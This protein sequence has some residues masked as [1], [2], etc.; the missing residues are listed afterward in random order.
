MINNVTIVT[1]TFGNPKWIELVDQRSRL[2]ANLQALQAPYIHV[3]TENS[4][5]D[6]RNEGAKRAETDFLCFLDADDFLDQDFILE[7]NKCISNTENREL[8]LFQ[9]ATKT[10]MSDE[11][12]FIIPRKKLLNSNFLII[13]TVV[14]RKVFLDIGGFDRD[15]QALEDWDLWIRCAIYGCGYTEVPS[16]IYEVANEPNSRNK[17]SNKVYSKIK[18]RYINCKGELL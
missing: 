1:G 4:L 15:L 11:Q 18:S 16:A 14:S 2:S 7:M 10:F 3:H 17:D 6:A 5:A 8:T 9:P 12:P 13:G